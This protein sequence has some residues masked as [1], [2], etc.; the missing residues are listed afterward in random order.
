ME[1]KKKE[2]RCE[3][4]WQFSFEVCFLIFKDQGKVKNPFGAS[5]EHMSLVGCFQAQH[6]NLPSVLSLHL[7]IPCMHKSDYNNKE[8]IFPQ[9]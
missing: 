5:D 2:K 7:C 6:F 3:L 8:N 9:V 4:L 1:K